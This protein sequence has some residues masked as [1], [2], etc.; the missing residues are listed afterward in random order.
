MTGTD[1]RSKTLR[2]LVTVAVWKIDA[3]QVRDRVSSDQV[4]GSGMKNHTTNPIPRTK[5][6]PVTVFEK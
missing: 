1:P 5:A 6:A 4:F 2:C 3:A